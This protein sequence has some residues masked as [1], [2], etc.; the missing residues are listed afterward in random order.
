MQCSLRNAKKIC[1]I[2][3]KNFFQKYG[4]FSSIFLWNISSSV[5]LLFLRSIYIHYTTLLHICECDDIAQFTTTVL[6]LYLT[7]TTGDECILRWNFFSD[8]IFFNKN[9]PWMAANWGGEELVGRLMLHSA[10][11][12]GEKLGVPRHTVCLRGQIQQILNRGGNIF[13]PQKIHHY[14]Y[15]TF[16]I[17]HNS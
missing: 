10:L 1:H 14:Y 13:F 12:Y 15:W 11:K 5:N 4:K 7:N 16:F 17:W 9:S 2:F 8:V 3:C 6:P